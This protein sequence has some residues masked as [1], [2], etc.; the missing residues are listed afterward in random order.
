MCI[1]LSSR[2]H[3]PRQSKGAPFIA[4]GAAVTSI[5]DPLLFVLDS[6]PV[7]LLETLPIYA[8]STSSFN[9]LTTWYS[10]YLILLRRALAYTGVPARFALFPL[11]ARNPHD[12]V[13]TDDCP[14]WILVVSLGS[15][16][17][18]IVGYAV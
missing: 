16:Q 7:T 3:P 4:Q 13:L 12:T 8:M 15:T 2:W 10:S 11:M 1:Y 18:S 6:L 5:H 14:F 17:S 9:A